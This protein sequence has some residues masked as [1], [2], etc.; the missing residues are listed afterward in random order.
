M[1]ELSPYPRFCGLAI[2]S[3]LLSPQA[4]LEMPL[5]CIIRMFDTYLAE[6]DDYPAFHVY[7][8]VHFLVRIY[9]W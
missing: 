7:F 1:D 2:F 9:G 3:Y 4:S 6:G 8:C 5:H